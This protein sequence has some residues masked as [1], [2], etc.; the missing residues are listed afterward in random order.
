MN[1]GFD[2]KRAANNLTGLGN[3]SRFVISQLVK[4]HPQNQ[5][6]IYTSK[7]K[8]YP[9]INV[10]L[11]LKGI[12]LKLKK[13]KLPLWRSLGIKKQLI[14]DK[15]DLY[16]GLSHEIPMGLGTI[17]P[18]IVTIHDVIFLLFPNNFGVIDRIIYK[19]KL[20]YACKSAD[21]IIAISERTKQD[22][23]QFFN[24][25]EQKIS[26]IYQSC[27]D[28]FKVPANQ[29]LKEEVKE[30]Y[31]LPENYILTVGTIEKRKNLVTLISA[32]SKTKT[33][34]KLIVVGKMT[35]FIAEVNA[36]IVRLNLQSRVI[37]LQDVSFN[38]LPSIYQMAEVFI[39]PSIYEGFGIPIIEALY[40]GI[41][42][43]AASGSCLE[44][45]GGAYSIYVNPHDA[46]GFAK[47]LNGII[48]N[49]EVKSKMVANGLIHVAKF[50]NEKLSD[51]MM[52]TYKQTITNFKDKYAT[53]RDR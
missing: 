19:F 20:G 44:E 40:S 8:D 37:F 13:T 30:R 36:E 16:H 41:P 10:F 4:S 6:F 46:D 47:A 25:D 11:K 52:E 49:P 43:V 21:H 18:A 38:D 23:I 9:Q 29:D 12:A 26:V 42:V 39:Y 45:A 51:Q 15:L 1:I 28:I 5:Y 31:Q 32:L 7:I 17:L 50:D 27:D 53:K 33:D 3:Y 35:S 22:I 24:V 14:E 34:Y 48:N 2:G